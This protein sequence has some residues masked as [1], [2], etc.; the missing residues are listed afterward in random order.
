[1]TIPDTQ[2]IT[3]ERQV[4][5]LRGV[6]ETLDGMLSHAS[7]TIGRLEHRWRSPNAERKPGYYL[8][9]QQFTLARVVACWGSMGWVGLTSEGVVA[10][11]VLAWAELP[12]LP[13]DDGYG[14]LV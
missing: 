8:V 3:L 7:A 14:G 12:A 6:V 4:E 1:M 9:V 5:E 11:G 13:S 2:E 10:I